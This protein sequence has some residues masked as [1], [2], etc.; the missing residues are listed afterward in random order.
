MGVR[1]SKLHGNVSIVF[2]SEYLRSHFTENDI[3]RGFGI[4]HGQL[5]IKSD[6]VGC[7]YLLESPRIIFETFKINNYH[8][9][10]NLNFEIESV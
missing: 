10:V 7:W 9:Q 4:S 2:F 8:Y 3:M 5:S 6:A 1:G